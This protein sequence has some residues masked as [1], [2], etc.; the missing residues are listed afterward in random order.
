MNYIGVDDESQQLTNRSNRSDRAN[1]L[2]IQNQILRQNFRENG[3][4]VDRSFLEDNYRPFPPNSG[5]NN[6]NYTNLKFGTPSSIIR[7][8]LD[9]FTFYDRNYKSDPLSA[10]LNCIELD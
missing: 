8:Q 3:L 1:K 7:N 5:D 10:K 6:N 9:M 4:E 2:K